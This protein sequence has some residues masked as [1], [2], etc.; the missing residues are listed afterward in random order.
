M[1]GTPTKVKC[2]YF[3]PTE[4]S[5]DK[6]ELVYLMYY[7]DDCDWEGLYHYTLEINN[8]VTSGLISWF[9]NPLKLQKGS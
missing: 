6:A 3:R 5:F 2:C 7:D 8:M 4:P 1:L 9:G